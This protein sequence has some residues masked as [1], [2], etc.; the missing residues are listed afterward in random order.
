MTAEARHNLDS[1]G[2]TAAVNPLDLDKP[3]DAKGA[4]R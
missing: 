4:S 3:T 1:E 2:A